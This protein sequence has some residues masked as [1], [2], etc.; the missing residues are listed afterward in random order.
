MTDFAILS[1]LVMSALNGAVAS[2]GAAFA[3]KQLEELLSR[4]SSGG[5]VPTYLDENDG[6]TFQER[7]Q[8]S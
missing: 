1:T 8:F 6:P 2:A 3:C 4:T 5:K 7:V